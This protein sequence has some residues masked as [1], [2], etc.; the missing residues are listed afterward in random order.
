MS[1]LKERLTLIQTLHLLFQLLKRGMIV[2]MVASNT[3][4]QKDKIEEGRQTEEPD[5]DIQKP[6]EDVCPVVLPSLVQ[7]ASAELGSA[8]L[9]TMLLCL[10]SELLH[11]STTHNSTLWNQRSPEHSSQ[12]LNTVPCWAHT[13]SL[14]LVA[15]PQA[16]NSQWGQRGHADIWCHTH[17]STCT[18]LSYMKM[19]THRLIRREA[20]RPLAALTQVT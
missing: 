2:L 10:P 17:E 13:L 19:N 16:T 6:P 3:N 14:A 18:H 12:C 15:Q 11:S 20:S 8:E 1:P 9:Y 4:K 7:A 5:T